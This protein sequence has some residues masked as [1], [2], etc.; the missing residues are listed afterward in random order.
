MIPTN[1][2]NLMIQSLVRV[3][4]AVM[5]GIVVVR[6][7]RTVTSPGAILKF[8]AGVPREQRIRLPNNWQNC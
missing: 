4:S 5:D 1:T 3:R 8:L 2:T 7:I 6:V